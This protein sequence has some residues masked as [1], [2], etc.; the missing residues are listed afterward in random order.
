V[1]PITTLLEAWIAGDVTALEAGR[2]I[3]RQRRELEDLDSEAVSALVRLF[4]PYP[5]DAPDPAVVDLLLH[6]L[7]MDDEAGDA[8]AQIA[9]E[10]AE[11]QALLVDNPARFY[12]F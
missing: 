12:R 4:P 9:P 2:R 11:R 6:A 10:A 3:D 7:R 5:A 8:L 1:S